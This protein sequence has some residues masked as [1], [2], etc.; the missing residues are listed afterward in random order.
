MSEEIKSENQAKEEDILDKVRRIEKVKKAKLLLKVMEEIKQECFKIKETKLGIK[1][2]LRLI[3]LNE[4]DIKRVI[5]YVNE[6]PACSLTSAVKNKIRTQLEED[7]KQKEKEVVKEV[8]DD[9]SGYV[10]NNGGYA[11]TNIGNQSGYV[12]DIGGDTRSNDS[13]QKL[14]LNL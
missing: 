2:R 14:T 11:W 1:E 3:G 10:W 8:V 6:L 9:Q 4:V 5:D 7:N 12:F 13:S